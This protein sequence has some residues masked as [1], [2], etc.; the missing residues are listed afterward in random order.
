M[1]NTFQYT[2]TGYGKYVKRFVCNGYCVIELAAVV[3]AL[4]EVCKQY[5][6]DCFWVRALVIL[7][8]DETYP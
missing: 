1:K 4:P 7:F 2:R 5:T 6:V 3:L 8:Q